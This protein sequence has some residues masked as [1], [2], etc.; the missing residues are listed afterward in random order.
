MRVPALHF[1]PFLKKSLQFGDL[2]EHTHI[3]FPIE[4][5]PLFSFAILLRQSSYQI[6]GF[7]SNPHWLLLPIWS[8]R[9]LVLNKEQNFSFSFIISSTQSFLIRFLITM[10]IHCIHLF[11]RIIFIK[12]LYV[13]IGFSIKYGRIVEC[14]TNKLRSILERLIAVETVKTSIKRISYFDWLK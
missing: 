4:L 8:Q 10:L 3:Q 5:N 2:L 13:S 11:I 9:I 7:S 14:T 12:I 6:R 1:F